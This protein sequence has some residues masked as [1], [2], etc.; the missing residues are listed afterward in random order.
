MGWGQGISRDSFL[1]TLKWSLLFFWATWNGFGS[2]L[3][4][5]SS[6]RLSSRHSGLVS[7]LSNAARASLFS[8]LLLVAKARVW[9]T[10]PLGV[11]VRHIICGFYLFIFPP[12]YVA[13]WGSKARHR[14]ANES[15]SWCSE[16]S[17]FFKTPF[18]GWSSI[19]T[20]FVSLFISYIF[21][22]L[23]SKT[24]G[25]LSGCLMSS[26]SIQKLFCG[27]YSA[28]KCSFFFF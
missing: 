10:P 8:P 13:L 6:L 15:V 27:N 4:Q 12:G 25:F 14:F 3:P 5:V 28:L 16:T 24:M 7:T 19:P 23:L 22:Y 2:S 18:P 26:A 21:S 11:A 17:L 9:A 20:S 1:R